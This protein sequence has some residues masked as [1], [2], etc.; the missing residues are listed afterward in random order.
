[1]EEG[2]REEGRDGE[3]IEEWKEGPGNTGE[4]EEE[5][6]KEEEKEEEGEDMNKMKLSGSLSFS[7]FT[8]SS[9][10]CR[11]WTSSAKI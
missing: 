9:P 11:F 10:F 5:E 6:E 3:W 7:D 1:M 8:S 2:G 4:Q